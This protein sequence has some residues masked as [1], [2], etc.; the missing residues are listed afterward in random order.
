MNNIRK[1][2]R[3][4]RK[5][6]KDRGSMSTKAL[7]I[8]ARLL[9]VVAIFIVLSLTASQGAHA[10][11]TRYANASTGSDAGNDCTNVSSPCK[12]ITRAINQS[13]AGDTISVAAGDYSAA[14]NGE[15]LPLNIDIDLTLNGAGAASTILDAANASRVMIIG[16]VTAN[17]SGLSFQ[18]GND[19]GV[20]CG[21]A[22]SA[23]AAGVNL[24]LANDTFSNNVAAAGDGGA[25]GQTK[26]TLT[27]SGSTFNSNSVP[28]NAAK[29]C[30][31]GAIEM[32]GNSSTISNSTFT[33]NSATGYGGAI[34]NNSVYSMTISSSTFVSNTATYGYGGAI[35]NTNGS[36][37]VAGSTFTGNV[38]TSGCCGG[39]ISSRGSSF[40]LNISNSTFS[41][42]N[43]GS[44]CCGGAIYDTI[45][46]GLSITG[47]T[48]NGNSVGGCCGGALDV[49][50]GQIANSTFFGNSAGSHGGALYSYIGSPIGV[51]N[52]TFSN[53]SAS[54]GGAVDDTTD[55]VGN[56][57]TLI[58]T[59]VANSP[60]GGN[61]AGGPIVPI[62][63]LQYNPNNT[64]GSMSVGDPKL[65]PLANN[66]GATQTMALGPGSAA[67]DA[68]SNTFCPALDQRGVTRIVAAD[69]RCDIGAYEYRS[70][71]LFL[72]LIM[73]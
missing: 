19:G 39:A 14:S 24:T 52:A 27:I 22:I 26:G 11:M 25:I 2:P 30:C 7:S 3:A 45:L 67:I 63:S 1:D 71:L 62:S 13:S 49:A 44:N 41:R 17:L 70:M 47:S 35:Y 6:E 65:A 46:G 60:S 66:G 16:G 59:I 37:Y 56:R 61:C 38:T 72:P 53:N 57:M 50:D 43:T 73:K 36:L 64:C 48:F 32:D 8:Q 40:I 69:P 33:N 34:L 29:P 4:L 20:C 55:L 23:M 28:N 10:A 5:S 51:T 31:G 21:G 58:N 9:I 42:N 18:N 15:T 12:T 68:G 54:V